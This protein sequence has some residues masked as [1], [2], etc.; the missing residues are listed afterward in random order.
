MSV[1]K[2][3]P[4]RLEVL[5][6]VLRFS[7]LEPA[8]VEALEAELAA[9][10]ARL[11]G[12]KARDRPLDCLR[13]LP[14]RLRWGCADED[15][16]GARARDET[17]DLAV[18]GSRRA[19]AVDHAR[20]SARAK[21][22]PVRAGDQTN[23]LRALL[24]T[25]VLDPESRPVRKRLRPQ[26][27][28]RDESRVAPASARRARLPESRCRGRQVGLPVSCW[29]PRDLISSCDRSRPFAWK[30]PICRKFTS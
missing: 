3:I 26:A 30:R 10:H 22:E 9:V 4:C 23:V 2:T 24:L 8:R 7:R 18:A 17:R 20:A 12:S 16:T 28:A 15:G 13:L 25:Q 19:I 6:A 21:P 29:D 27:P 14:P 5:F 1:A 11:V